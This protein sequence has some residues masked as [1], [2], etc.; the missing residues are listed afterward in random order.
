MPNVPWALKSLWAHP[1]V[2]LGV[3]GQVKA[4]LSLFVDSVNLDAQ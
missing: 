4:R 2:L 1:M 3:V